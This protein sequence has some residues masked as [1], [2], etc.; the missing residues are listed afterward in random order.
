MTFIEELRA[1]FES[2]TPNR[3]HSR[4]KETYTLDYAIWRFL[5][6]W[7]QN[8]H[9][10]P[11]LVVLLRQ[12]ARWNEGRLF[13]GKLP[14]SLMQYCENAGLDVTPAGDLI[15]EPFL[16]K[17]LVNDQMTTFD[18]IDAKPEMRRCLESIPAEAYLPPLGYKTWQ[19]QAQKEAAWLTLTAQR[20]TTTLVAL[21]TG[22]GKSLCF[23]L[24]SRFET[25]LTVVVVPTV[26]LAMDQWRSAL[27]V[28][29]HIP[30][31]NPQYFASNDSDIDPDSIV[32]DVREGRTRL[33]FTSPEACV[34]GRLRK[35]LEEAA[36]KRQLENLVVDEAHMIESWGAYFRVDF[37]MLSM[38]RRNWLQLSDG[39]VR[40]FLLSAT[41]TRNSRDLLRN[42]FGDGEWREFV[43]QRLRPEITYYFRN[44]DSEIARMQATVECAWRLPRPAILYTT[45][46]D[47]AKRLF[48]TLYQDEGFRRVGCFHG[49]TPPSERRS[50][51]SRWRN[52]EIDT[53]VATS[54]FGLGVDKADVRSVVHAC[55][56]ENMHR[57]YQEVGRGG[58]DGA[59]SLS[60]LL[61]TDKD[62][63]VA[64][65]LAPTLLSESLVQQR[66]ESMWQTREVVSEDNHI[67]K[68]CTDARRTGLLGT[69]TWNENIRWN[70]RLIL[71]LLRAS[72]LDLLDVEY[73]QAADTDPIEWITVQLHFPPSSPNVGASI[74]V[75]REQELR[76]A[77]D[78]LQ[79]M[80]A[81]MSGER[82]ICRILQKLYGSGTQRVC[83]G[84]PGCRREGRS[85]GYC[86][87][88]EFELSFAPHPTHK[89]ITSVPNPLQK[90][91]ASLLRTKL[92]QILRHKR[93]RRFACARTHYELMLDLLS[94]TFR[95]TDPDMY[96][97]D[98][99]PSEPHFD[100]RPDET[101]MFFHIGQLTSE[102]LDLRAG[103]EV[104]HMIC[105][106]VN[107]LD[108]NSRYP[109]EADGW[110][111]YPTLES[112]L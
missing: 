70:K 66:W 81:Y 64:Q 65:S 62:I 30:D 47:D 87:K 9:L 43:S 80:L 72:K 61:P 58:R 76:V 108:S 100:V 1:S 53:M 101:I 89:V 82:P 33:V 97:L 67:W 37:Q 3:Q 36:R 83:F 19:S 8:P 44:F 16:P 56:P 78:G 51:L 59:S 57:Y 104:I 2:G 24:L 93:I 10:G 6:V 77:Y 28:L 105:S 35:V 88:L 41:F 50:L 99:L 15:A 32:S 60:I 106:G 112:W 102:A 42:L 69:R 46:V 85:F 111:F 4:P 29:Q 14:P 38:L 96:R 91:G 39:S 95:E 68:L 22:S 25:G 71:Q 109:G 21:P 40:T 73:Q 107:Y 63:K 94:K 45:E 75:E 5:R 52:D 90:N 12:I 49:E 48:K 92:W 110:R 86:P 103:K 23:Q 11:D 31:L 13:V 17:W 34:S 79:Q 7:R 54:A 18:G 84:C 26:A 20:G 98:S 55:L 27:Q 74:S